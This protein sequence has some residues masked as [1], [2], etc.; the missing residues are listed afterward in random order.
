[1]GAIA[2]RVEKSLWHEGQHPRRPDGEF[3]GAF[4]EKW[5]QGELEN[6]M[7]SIGVDPK[8]LKKK[9]RLRFLD[10]V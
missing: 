2:E 7:R 6:A 5:T 10:R 8:K 4:G 9:H 3:I 1:M